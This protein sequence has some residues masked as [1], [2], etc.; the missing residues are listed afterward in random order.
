MTI[1]NLT[2]GQLFSIGPYHYL[3]TGTH[4]VFDVSGRRSISVNPKA[5]L[6]ILCLHNMEVAR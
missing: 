6:P 5:A 4:R 2:L 3:K 1:K